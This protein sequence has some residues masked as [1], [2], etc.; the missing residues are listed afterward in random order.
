VHVVAAVADVVS[1]A[2]TVSPGPPVA[3]AATTRALARVS[4]R[5]RLCRRLKTGRPTAVGVTI[6]VTGARG[7]RSVPSS[8]NPHS[9]PPAAAAPSRQSARTAAPSG[10]ERTACPTPQWRT[11]RSSAA[12]RVHNPS[13]RAS[14]RRSE[15]QRSRLCCQLVV[16]AGSERDFDRTADLPVPA[17]GSQPEPDR[18]PPVPCTDTELARHRPT[19]PW[20]DSPSIAGHAAHS[21]RK[22]SASIQ[23]PLKSTV[24]TPSKAGSVTA[25]P[26]RGSWCHRSVDCRTPCT[27]SCSTV[28]SGTRYSPLGSAAGV[29]YASRASSAAADKAPNNADPLVRRLCNALRG[30]RTRSIADDWSELKMA[31]NA[32]SDFV[33]IASLMV[34]AHSAADSTRG[35]S[36][37][38]VAATSTR[39]PLKFPHH[40][41]VS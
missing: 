39:G 25:K 26:A 1:A 14:S 37:V 3:E 36:T 24:S 13:R 27:D 10:P 20:R 5:N 6:A 33:A 28:A 35:M 19:V 15:G 11:R 22:V 29:R 23:L 9:S 2:G 30:S 40:T 17:P 4:G 31:F 16:I 41:W 38:L 21:A 8:S 18:E 34:S 12:S 32:A 7:P